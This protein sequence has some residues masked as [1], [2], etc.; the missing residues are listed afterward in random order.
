MPSDALGCTRNTIPV[1][2][3][4]WSPGW[5]IVACNGGVNEEFLVTVAHQAMVNVSL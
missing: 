1:H 5:G 2:W 3:T 4:N